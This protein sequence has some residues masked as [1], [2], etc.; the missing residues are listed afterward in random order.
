M[1][2]ECTDDNNGI[3]SSSF[4]MEIKIIHQSVNSTRRTRSREEKNII[5]ISID[6]LFDQMSSFFA[7]FRRLLST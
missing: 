4:I 5:F 3:H 6:W 2:F 1:M 7:K